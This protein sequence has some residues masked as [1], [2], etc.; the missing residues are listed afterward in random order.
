MASLDLLPVELRLQIWAL[1]ISPRT[2]K[3][4]WS[5]RTARF[6]SRHPPP[7]ILQITSES[8]AYGLAI[9]VLAFA[10]SPEDSRIY[11]SYA[12]DAADFQWSSLASYQGARITY[13]AM[14]THLGILDHGCLRRIA[15]REVELIGRACDGLVDLRRFTRLEVISVHCD[16]ERPNAEG[17]YG[18]ELLDGLWKGLDVDFD[19]WDEGEEKWPSLSCSRVKSHSGGA[20]CFRHRWFAQWNERCQVGRHRKWAPFLAECVYLTRDQHPSHGG[21]QY[22]FTRMLRRHWSDNE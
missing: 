6:Y 9:Y 7:S 3:I 2:V 1:V 11:F 8:R 17:S 19:K 14:S 20:P 21:G 18:E 5:P 12:L 4:H 13:P 15:I 10:S 22:L 16:L